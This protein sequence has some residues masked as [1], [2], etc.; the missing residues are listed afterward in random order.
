M[1]VLPQR[2]LTIEIATIGKEGNHK[3]DRNDRE[4]RIRVWPCE[5]GVS[6]LPRNSNSNSKWEKVRMN[7]PN[8][9]PSISFYAQSLPFLTNLLPTFSFKRQ[10][11]LNPQSYHNGI[12]SWGFSNVSHGDGGTF[13]STDFQGSYQIWH[14]SFR[15]LSYPAKYGSHQLA[16]RK[17]FIK[18]S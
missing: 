14:L 7:D 8:L 4:S 9:F 18:Q 13:M 15:R 2:V 1:H 5:W 16:L 11:Y 17:L 12:I 6:V 10:P 3:M